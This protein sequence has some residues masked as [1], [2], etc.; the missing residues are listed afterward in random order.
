MGANAVLELGPGGGNLMGAM[1]GA[2]VVANELL[3]SVLGKQA[4]REAAEAR[5]T[6]N[7]MYAS[8]GDR[9]RF[10]DGGDA[11]R[12]RRTRPMGPRSIVGSHATQLL[13][14]GSHGTMLQQLGSHCAQLLDVGSHGIHLLQA[15]RRAALIRGR[16]RLTL[17][18][19]CP[20]A[21]E[22]DFLAQQLHLTPQAEAALRKGKA[23]AKAKVKATPYLHGALQGTLKGQRDPIAHLSRRSRWATYW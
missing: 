19:G 11:V 10:G 15:A 23:K 22:I 8:L 4:G 14:V 5:S 6:F 7:N 2:R 12:R 17:P 21:Q 1:R 18:H 3:H 9:V 16:C 13:H 20:S